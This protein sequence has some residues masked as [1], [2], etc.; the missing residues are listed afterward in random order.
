[1]FINTETLQYPVSEQDIKA[2]NPNASFPVPFVAP[3][4]YSWVFPA[5]QPAYDPISQV[6]REIAPELTEKGHYEQR[7]EVVPRFV[8]YTDP[9]DV[10]HTVAEQI[11]AAQEAILQ[12][13]RKAMICSPRQ[14]RQALTATGLRAAVEAGVA[15]GDQDIKDWYEF[16]TAFERLH[17]SVIALATALAVSETQ[18]DDLFALAGSL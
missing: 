7:Y 3:D 13:K 9:E 6:V 11:A 18:L 14:I 17:P 12:D 2:A 16:A 1:M 15:A 8:E 4:P 10:V 5:P